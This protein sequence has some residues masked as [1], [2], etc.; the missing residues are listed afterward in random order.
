MNNIQLKRQE[1]VMDPS[2]PFGDDVL[3]RTQFAYALEEL[4]SDAK[5]PLVIALNGGW[6]T[7]K[8]FFLERW[9]ARLRSKGTEGK[10]LP[11]A[12]SYNAWQDDDLEDPLLALVGQLH[13]YLHS[14]ARGGDLPVKESLKSKVDAKYEK[15]KEPNI[16]IAQNIATDF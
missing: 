6:G 3:S 1:E 12:I 4:V 14:K 7:G 11:C 13:H 8:T 15:L 10:E 16:M 5:E 2:N 9:V